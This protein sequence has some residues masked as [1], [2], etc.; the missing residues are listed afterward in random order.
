LNEWARRPTH[1]PQIDREL[2]RTFVAPDPAAALV[3]RARD[4]TLLTGPDPPRVR[5]GAGCALLFV[6]RSRPGR[7]R[8]CSMDRCG[9]REKTARYGEKKQRV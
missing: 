8:S 2:D 5:T 6:D 7:R 4:L 3:H 9:N 1:A